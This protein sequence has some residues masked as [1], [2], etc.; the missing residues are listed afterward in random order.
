[1]HR[2]NGELC[3]GCRMYRA[4]V[5]FLHGNSSPVVAFDQGFRA[6]VWRVYAWLDCL[7]EVRV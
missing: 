5:K 1:M 7:G 4:Y 2:D 3:I 6:W